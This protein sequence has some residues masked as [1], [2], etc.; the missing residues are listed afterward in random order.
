M[1]QKNAKRASKKFVNKSK[2]AALQTI[3]QSIPQNF[4]EQNL[5][6]T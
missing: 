1:H 2:N 3:T 5:P 6:V 4:F